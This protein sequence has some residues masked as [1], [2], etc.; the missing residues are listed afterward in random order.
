MNKLKARD[1]SI[2]LSGKFRISLAARYMTPKYD[3]G[4]SD[5]RLRIERPQ[6]PE[7][8]GRSTQ[9]KKRINH[10]FLPCHQ[11]HPSVA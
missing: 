1:C 9:L 3:Y 8:S 7:R 2:G 11:T 4:N 6:Q 5:P 10:R